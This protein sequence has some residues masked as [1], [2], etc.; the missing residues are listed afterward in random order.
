MNYLKKIISASTSYFVFEPND[1]YSWNKWIDMVEP[2]L[3][4]IKNLR[5]VYEYK[6]QMK[7][8]ASEIENNTMPGTIWIKPTKTAE[9]IPL[10]FMI[11]PFQR[12][13]SLRKAA[14]AS[15]PL[16]KILIS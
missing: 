14:A 16:C 5:G 12:L 2:K 7:H 8:T 3:E 6:V 1:Q 13:L 11:A 4:N 15:P 9:F 10:S